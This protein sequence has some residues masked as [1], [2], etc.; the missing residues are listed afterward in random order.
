MER[1]N[2]KKLKKVRVMELLGISL[3][4]WKTWMIMRTLTGL[5]NELGR[6]PSLQ[7]KRVLGV[8]IKSIINHGFMKNSQNYYR[9]ESSVNCSGCRVQAKCMEII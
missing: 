8:M 3:Q 9:K 5:G 4:P 6:I 7:I 2:L 1:F